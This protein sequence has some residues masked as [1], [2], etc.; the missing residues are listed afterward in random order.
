MR[1][2]SDLRSSLWIHVKGWLF[3]VIVVLAGGALLLQ[4]PSWQNAALLLIALWA[5]SRWYYYA[6]YVVEKYV[7]PSYRY[8][9]LGHLIRYLLTRKSNP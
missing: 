4:I 3:L 1:L 8:A 7:D 5:V 6:F 9:G 2:F